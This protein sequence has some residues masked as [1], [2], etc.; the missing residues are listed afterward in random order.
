MNKKSGVNG[1]VSHRELK[2][3]YTNVMRLSMFPVS[4][5]NVKVTI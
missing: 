5:T 2:I 1:S 4:E 3:S